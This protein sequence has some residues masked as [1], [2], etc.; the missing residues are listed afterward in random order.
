MGWCPDTLDMFSTGAPKP[1]VL[2]GRVEEVC[3]Q[4]AAA[5]FDA[6]LCDPP[7]GLSFMSKGWDHS[8]PS[9]ELWREVLRVAKPGAFLMAFGGTRLFHRTVCGI[10]DAGFE[11]KHVIG[12]QRYPLANHIG[13]LAEG[14]P[15]GHVRRDWL[16][17]RKSE[18]AYA[19]FLDKID[20][21]DTIIATAVKP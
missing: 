1:V 14:Q 17:D 9:P 18:E 5:S 8:V 16:R 21:T 10:E 4:L 15:G 2:E 3:P 11:V 6:V 12:Y 20:A 7:Y 13:W 19:E